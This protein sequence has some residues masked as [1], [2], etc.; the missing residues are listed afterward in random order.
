[1]SNLVSFFLDRAFLP[2]SIPSSEEN[3]YAPASLPDYYKQTLAFNK[4]HADNAFIILQEKYKHENSVDVEPLLQTEEYKEIIHIFKTK[5]PRYMTDAF[6]FNTTIRVFLFL[7]FII[8]RDLKDTLH[9]EGDNL[10]FDDISNISKFFKPGEF[11]FC[12]EAPSASAPCCIFVKDSAAAQT[13]LNLHVKL[14]KKGEEALRSHVG[15]FYSWITDMA[16]LDLIYKYGKNYKM[17]PCVPSGPFSENFNEMQMLFDP[18]P[19][20]MFFGGTNP[21]HPPG[22]V[23]YRHY[24]GKELIE[25]SITVEFD[26]KPYAIYKGK[27]IPIFNLHM[28][29]KKCIEEFIKK[30]E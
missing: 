12:N 8:K 9:L 7:I 10:I 15:H 5:W 21:N 19:Y 4:K 20:G 16:L 24:V 17:L 2:T 25:K 11:G 13:L 23:E 22:Y 27:K 1:M 29:N 6:W 26:K 28:H 30:S 18:N 14:I 3:I